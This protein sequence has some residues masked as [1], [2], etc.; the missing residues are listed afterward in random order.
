MFKILDREKFG[1][2]PSWF[3]RE[4]WE[5]QNNYDYEVL[6]WRKC[7]N[8]RAEILSYLEASDDE[9]EW[10]LSLMDLQDICKILKKIYTKENWDES[11]SIWSWD[12]IKET[13][14]EN[15]RYACRVLKWLNTKPE[16]SYRLYFYDSY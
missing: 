10:T 7:W 1:D 3:K 15:L 14:I 16:G 13:Y 9:Y 8:V 6:Y 12:E 5:D 11:Q 2:I 4:A